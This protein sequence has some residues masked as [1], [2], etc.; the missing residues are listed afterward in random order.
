MVVTLRDVAKAAGVSLSTASRALHD[1]DSTTEAMRQRVW[2]V[3][4][5]LQ[6][7]P[8]TVA[9]SLRTRRTDTIGLLVP[10]VR[11][12]FFTDLAYS[13]DKAAAAAGLTVMIGNSDESTSAADRFL[14]NLARHQVDGL[15]VVPQGLASEALEQA[16][17]DRPTV[18]L[19]RHPD[20]PGVS[21]ADVP[22]VTSGDTDG[23][24]A[25]IDHVV[26]QGYRR[27]GF[28]SGPT[29]ASTGRAR[30]AAF[31]RRLG[32]LGLPNDES[33]VA[34]GDFR[35]QSGLCAA[36]ELLARPRR[37]D[38][39]I[40]ADNPMALGV[41][42]ELRRRRLRIGRDIGFAAI[43]DN[44]WFEVLDP[45][46][47]VV[48]HDTMRMARTAISALVDLIEGRPATSTV[49]PTRLVVRQSLG[50][51]ATDPENALASPLDET[52]EVTRR[53]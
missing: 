12:P 29:T 39:I 40:A 1:P 30:H 33:L 49:I 21:E 48:A 31:V 35:L 10:D 53:G 45:P 26:A 13:V 19:D 51:P 23:M 44:P 46:V 4:D 11:N 32:D 34:Y 43:D 16:A 24:V 52:P 27:I 47:T 50:E 36:E 17:A 9:R 38:A 2:Q 18:F 28:I 14:T 5:E 20:L 15:L 3:A 7:R 25:L 6:Y 41:L 37:P 22:V 42:T 8:N